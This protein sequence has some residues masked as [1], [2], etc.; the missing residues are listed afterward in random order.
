[1]KSIPA[2]ILILSLAT[3]TSALAKPNPTEKS[4]TR[5]DQT[6]PGATVEN[7]W[8]IFGGLSAGY[9]TI[10]ESGYDNA[11]SGG[12]YLLGA[13]LSY[14]TSSWVMDG[15]LSWLYSKVQ[16]NPAPNKS[17]DIRTRAGLLEFSPRKRLSERFQL[18]PTFVAAL[19]TDTSFSQNI[20]SSSVTPLAGLKLAYEVPHPH[21]PVRLTAQ[22]T[23]DFTLKNRQAL[24]SWVGVHVGLPIR[25]KSKSNDEIKVSFATQPQPEAPTVRVVLDPQKV[26]FATNSAQ[27]KPD[28]LNVLKEVG[29]YLNDHPEVF[30]SVEIAGHADQR[31]RF[32]YNMKLSQKRATS[33]RDALMS[34]GIA[35]SRMK[36]EAYSFTQP[37]IPKNNPQA[38]SLNRRVE[39]IFKDV[40][41]PEELIEI[42]KPLTSVTIDSSKQ[43]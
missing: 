28:V 11:P 37:M 30:K 23:T 43:G 17:V 27:I 19:G 36:T 10:F 13:A 34:G 25:A 26:F 5:I 22:A 41:N 12:Q 4:E 32:D 33:V 29:D 24:L 7:G 42:I 15:G 14:T 18:G 3:T 21:F 6:N 31:G 2:S 8:K 1:M 35:S 16:G 38:W 39:L 9:G 20:G 40:Q